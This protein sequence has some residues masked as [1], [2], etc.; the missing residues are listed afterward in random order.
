MDRGVMSRDLNEWLSQPT[1]PEPATILGAPASVVPVTGP[2][3]PQ[4]GVPAPDL[5]DQLPS[6]S[7][8]HSAELWWLGAHGGAG[9]TSLASLVPQ[10]PAASHGWPYVPGA[11]ASRVVVVARTNVRGLRAAQHAAAQ[12][13]SGLVPHAQVLG[14]VIVPDTPGRL[15]R[16][17]RDLSRLVSGGFPRTWTVPW[18][19]SWRMGEPPALSTAPREVRRLVDDLRSLLLP[20]AAGTTN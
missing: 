15:P 7:Q 3:A 8:A 18:V 17:L 9:E 10:W 5:V 11:A 19:E 13:A 12:W 16:P 4:E 1:A 2:I 14:L 20:G 6:F